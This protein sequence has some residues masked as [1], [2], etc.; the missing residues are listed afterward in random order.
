MARR[1]SIT[2]SQEVLKELSRFGDEAEKGVKAITAA[3]ALE[4]QAD[5]SDKAPVNLGKLK[6]SINSQKESDFFWT[7]NVNANYGAFVEFGTGAKVKVPA[8]L[9]EIAQ[10]YKGVKGGG[11]DDFLERISDWCKQKGIDEKAAYV[12]A[13]SILRKGIEPQPYL[14]PAFVKGK[15]TYI[16]DLK[17]LLS[18]LKAKYGK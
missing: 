3:T 13:V 1:V 11:F 16:N 8:E 15:R 7:V 10:Q 12:I 14:Y 18:R 4:I 9:S 5:A 17:G 6:Q 2:G